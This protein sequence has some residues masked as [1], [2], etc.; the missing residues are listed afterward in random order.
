MFIV[1]FKTEEQIKINPS[2][3]NTESTFMY[4]AS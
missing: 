1:Q 3:K 4:K 2:F